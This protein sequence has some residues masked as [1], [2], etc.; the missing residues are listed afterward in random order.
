MG[1]TSDILELKKAIK[2]LESH[3][4]ILGDSVVN[5]SVKVMK[6]K[7]A[8][9]K[10][11]ARDRSKQLRRYVTVMFA[12][13]SG[14]TSICSKNDAENVTTAINTLWSA[15]DSIIVSNG[16]FVDKHIGDCVMAVWG[17]DGVREDDSARA[18]RAALAIQNATKSISIDSA[19]LIP[20]FSLRTGIHSGHVFITSIGL[21]KEYTVM[22]DTVNVANRLQ[23]HAPLGSVL[24]SYETWKH[25]RTDYIFQQ[26]PPLQVKGVEKKLDTYIVKEIVSDLFSQISTSF[27]GIETAMVGRE[28]ELS[29][30]LDILNSIYFTGLTGMITLV[31]EAGIGK[32][33]LLHEFNRAIELDQR[34]AIFF[35]ARCTPDMLDIP[36][37]IFRDILRIKYSVKEND[38]IDILFRKLETGMKDILSVQEIHLACNFVGFDMSSSQYIQRVEGDN[39]LA[40]AGRTALVRYFKVI[41]EQGRTLINLED[42]HWADSVS[43]SIIEEIVKKIPEEKLLVICLT[44]PPLLERNPDWGKGLPNTFVYLEPLSSDESKS[45]VEVILQRIQNLSSELIN[46]ITANADGNPFYVEELIKMLVEDNVISTENWT[47]NTELFTKEKVPST[48]T[49]VLQARLDSLSV[50][51][52]NFLQLASVIGR[53]FWDKVIKDISIENP[54]KVLELLSLAESH[55]L[56]HK[57]SFSTF[58]GASEYLFKHAILRDV[59]YETVL[60]KARKRYHNL[61]AAWLEKN[62][63]ERI[64]EFASI[65]AH[66][67]ESGE[68][69][70]NAV[71]WLVRSGKLAMDHSAYKEALSLFQRALKAPQK[72]IKKIQVSQIH[73]Y[74]GS[75]I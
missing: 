44:R 28:K 30:F 2:A 1:E 65:I 38:S 24:V 48:L 39:S 12:D 13:V 75:C 56:V 67:F 32:S 51:E 7:I 9:L 19:G 35:N 72:Y 46:L 52:R 55:D 16:G 60:L 43:L 45:L 70:N 3:R 66:H 62:S 17:L 23:T 61:V 22:G 29:L 50:S 58:S 59:T 18:I 4:S 47:V 73:F 71:K 63:K 54:D 31:G 41:A 42:L 27:F 40:A 26:Q 5:S 36:C 53:A 6:E 11:K 49:G 64:D 15:L 21:N 14:F 20:P 74:C 69:W 57:M 25:T 33:R 37:A 68:D 10:F 8:V 34:K